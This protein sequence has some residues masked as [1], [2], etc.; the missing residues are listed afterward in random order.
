MTYYLF[1]VNYEYLAGFR[2]IRPD[3][4]MTGF[5]WPG[6]LCTFSFSGA[7]TGMDWPWG[8]GRIFSTI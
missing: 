3:L 8:T 5:S 1:S 6:E 4:V 7:G 2:I